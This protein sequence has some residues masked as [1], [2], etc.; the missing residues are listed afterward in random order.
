MSIATLK[1]KT[2][3][4]YKNISTDRGQFS[5]NG[6]HRSQGYVGQTSLSRSLPRTLM[7][8][9]I[10]RGHGGCCGTYPILTIVQSAVTSL[11]DPTVVKSSVI[12]TS[13]MIDERLKCIYNISQPY[14][15]TCGSKSSS[16][17]VKP[18]NN[19]NLNR[20]SDYIAL[21]SNKTIQNYDLSCNVHN[22]TIIKPC[23]NSSGCVNK[24]PFFYRGKA[25][26]THSKPESSYVPISQSQ[27]LI[28]KNNSCVQSNTIN[29]PNINALK[30]PLPGNTV[31]R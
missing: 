2:N 5:L 25:Y 24:D 12:N 23:G 20:Q 10:I 29:I 14:Y 3:A 7:N 4:T 13:G 15:E 21:K 1:R 6:T 19:N 16:F 8:G 30:T 26:I 18:D 11:N 27:Y 28:K 22:D 9:N 17:T 31:S